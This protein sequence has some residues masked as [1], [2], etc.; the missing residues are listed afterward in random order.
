MTTTCVYATIILLL[1]HI[2]TVSSHYPSRPFHTA[3]LRHFIRTRCQKRV[4]HEDG[5]G[6][7]LWAYEGTLVDPNN[8]HM[9]AEVEGLELVDLIDE[10]FNPHHNHVDGHE[11]TALCIGRS[12]LSTPIRLMLSNS[13]S[14]DYATTIQ[15]R[16]L[17]CY[18]SPDDPSQLLSS[19]RLPHSSS[20]RRVYN[21]GA[22]ASYNTT[23]TYVSRNNGKELVIHTAWPEKDGGRWILSSADVVPG[24]SVGTGVEIEEG[25]NSNES[26]R[27]RDDDKNTFEFTTHT[28]SNGNNVL[29]IPQMPVLSLSTN[30]SALSALPLP[31]SRFVQFGQWNQQ[32][33]YGFVREKYLYSMGTRPIKRRRMLPKLISHIPLSQNIF[34]PCSSRNLTLASVVPAPSSK[35]K[36]RYTRYGEAPPWY[37]LRRTAIL[38][39]RG[40]RIP[41]IRDSTPL[42]ATLAAEVGF[43]GGGTMTLERKV[44]SQRLLNHIK[45]RPGPERLMKMIRNRMHLR[46]TEDD[47]VYTN[48]DVM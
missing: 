16:K 29:D 17:F 13:S 48:T 33:A 36:V 19:L 24:L 14:W 45:R 40:R 11:H 31:R 9:I 46:K 27:D 25:G 8:G 5:S 4:L 7:A 32:R 18:R 34:Q 26:R 21:H 2:P 3:R 22:M 28:R 30:S 42:I 23:T 44:G 10:C 20:V 47:E 41:C 6:P 12:N 15:S 35:C 1:V 43:G 38:E 37:G 39:L